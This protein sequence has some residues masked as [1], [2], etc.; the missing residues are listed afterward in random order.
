MSIWEGLQAASFKPDGEAEVFFAIQSIE[1]DGGNRLVKRA[2][3]YR[4]GVKLDSTGPKEHSWKVS[5]IFHNSLSEIGLGDSPA[6]YPDRLQTLESY[7]EKQVTGT[8]NLPLERNLRVRCDTYNR[9]ADHTFR[10]GEIFS[11]T[12][13]E[14]NEESAVVSTNVSV[15]STI[16]TAVE[17]AIFDAESCGAWE[18]PLSQLKD[19][20]A[21]LN[22]MMSAP[23][24]FLAG[25]E[26]KAGVVAKCAKSIKDSLSGKTLMN[27]E[28]S[29]TQQKLNE[30]IDAAFTAKSQAAGAPKTTT[31]SWST[32]QDIFAIGLELDQDPFELIKLNTNLRDVGYIPAGVPVVVFA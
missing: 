29:R 19:L 14:D 6:I 10:D 16:V 24:E 20:A 4:P 1:K 15:K 5:M 22:G 21:E 17:E 2:R 30:L 26:Q 27:P 28:G 8:L 7:C 32:P 13:V 31:R 3:P 9:R 18:S 23:G 25:I 11:V 12:F